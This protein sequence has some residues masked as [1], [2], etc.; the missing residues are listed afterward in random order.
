MGHSV[1]SDTMSD[2]LTKRSGSDRSRI[3]INQDF[4]RRSWAKSLGVTEEELKEAV[5]N[6]GDRAD[7]VR[8][9][10]RQKPQRKGTH[11]TG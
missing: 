11:G 4:E 9:Y 8:E 3:N 6:V 7:K 10:L 5:H 2:D 1:W